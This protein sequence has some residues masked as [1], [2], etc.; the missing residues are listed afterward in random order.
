LTLATVVAVAA[1]FLGVTAPNAG[2][3]DDPVVTVTPSTDLVDGQVVHVSVRGTL[4]FSEIFVGLCAAGSTELFRCDSSVGTARTTDST[5][6]SELDVAVETVFTTSTST[7]TVAVDCRVAPGCQ[8]LLYTMRTDGS[9]AP[10][11]APLAFD[12]D[13]PLLPSATLATTPANG[14]VDGQ[15]IQVT[16]EHFVPTT[17]VALK[18]CRVPTVDE[19]TDCEQPTVFASVAA[20]G[21]VSTSFDLVAIVRPLRQ[22]SFDCRITACALVGTRGL[23][24]NDPRRTAS[25]PLD[26]AAD[27]PL[28]PPPTLTVT[29]AT[30]L[31]TGQAVTVNGSGFRADASFVLGECGVGPGTGYDRCYIPDFAFADGNGN[32]TRT[33]TVSAFARLGS[34]FVDCRTGAHCV[35]AA[36]D[37]DEG[38]VLTETPIS[39][40]P[41]GPAPTTPSLSAAPATALPA[42]SPVIVTGTRYPPRQSLPVRQCT[43]QDGLPKECVDAA[44][45][46]P[47]P[48]D[49]GSFVAGVVVTATIT[50]PSGAEV[51]CR[52]TACGLSAAAFGGWPAVAPLTFAPA[53][54]P[55]DPGHDHHHHH[56]GDGHHHHHHHPDRDHGHHGWD[57]HRHGAHHGRHW[58]SRR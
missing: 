42:S 37:I 21:T 25:V 56:G 41:A 18:Q 5:G 12:P 51:D 57:H 22:P 15:R 46:N 7:G 35:I 55:P 44:L 58:T 3:V 29:P 10:L 49:A 4:P 33:L 1:V 28:S 31:T 17:A 48:D 2:A 16:G 32:V 47:E 40:D 24:D 27:G 50:L 39:F 14:L 20:D 8:L 19:A 52:M 43:L 34:G 26:F 38:R 45:A 23:V 30:G 11:S 13:A 53:A 54:P 9:F 6:A 36:V